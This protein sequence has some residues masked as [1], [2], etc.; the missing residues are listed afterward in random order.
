VSVVSRISRSTAAGVAGIVLAG[1]ATVGF[2]L[3]PPKRPPEYKTPASFAAEL[4]RARTTVDAGSGVT[5]TAS[6]SS[7]TSRPL[8]VDGSAGSQAETVTST[9][10]TTATT[11]TKRTKHTPTRT[12]SGLSS[13]RQT[14]AFGES[15]SRPATR[16]ST[17]SATSA[18]DT[19]EAP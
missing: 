8:G 5:P 19:T 15:A 6:S 7:T 4:A 14:S 9:S 2:V 13:T 11:T 16:T 18:T 10:E 12:S 3:A 1:A 17:T